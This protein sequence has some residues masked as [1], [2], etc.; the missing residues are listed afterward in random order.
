MEIFILHA[1][2]PL[3]FRLFVIKFAVPR[4]PL[5]G[6]SSLQ[7]NLLSLSMVTYITAYLSVLVHFLMLANY[8]KFDECVCVNFFLF[9]CLCVCCTVKFILLCFITLTNWPC[10][11]C[12]F[13]CKAPPRKDESPV[14]MMV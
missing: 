14:M 1:L 7:R 12:W 6:F 10:F 5:I 2:F 9:V 3:S 4:H 11:R 8:L 13:L